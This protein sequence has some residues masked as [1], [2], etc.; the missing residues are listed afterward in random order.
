MA[1]PGESEA[2]GPSGTRKHYIHS[3][4]RN[5]TQGCVKECSEGKLLYPI[6]TP[7]KRAYF[8]TGVPR[9]TR[10]KRE[11]ENNPECVLESPLKRRIPSKKKVEIESF[12]RNVIRMKMEDFHIRQK[13]VPSVRKLLVAMKQKIVFPWQK[14]VLIR[15]LHDMGF[16]WK[17]SVSKRKMFVERRDM[18]DWRCRY[19]IKMRQAT[20]KLKNIFFIDETWVDSNLTFRKRW[21][22]P[23][24]RG[25]MDTVSGSNRLIVVHIGSK[26]GFLPGAQLAYKANSTSG[27]MNY[28]N[29][30]DGSQTESFSTCRPTVLWLWIMRLITVQC[31]TNL[32]GNMPVNKV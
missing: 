27:Q 23:G 7:V 10:I 32:L 12:D 15:V 28:D 24:I 21:Q 25:M 20:E 17:R 5:V 18:I 9:R 13:I 4:E 30:P 22:G 2:A 29:F 31:T 19:L 3:K 16:T 8:Y 11:R 26:D 14:D 6:T 1:E